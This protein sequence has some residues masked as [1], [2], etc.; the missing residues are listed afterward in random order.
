MS[1]DFSHSV[2]YKIICLNQDIKD[3]Y[4]GSTVKFERRKCDHKQACANPNGKLYNLK[5]YKCIRENGGWENWD[6]QIVE[7]V[8][9]KD[10]QELRARESYYKELLCATLNVATPSIFKMLDDGSKV[11]CNPITFE[12]TYYKEPGKSRGQWLRPGE[13]PGKRVIRGLGNYK[14]TYHEPKSGEGKG[15]YTRTPI[16]VNTL[17]DCGEQKIS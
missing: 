11:L 15:Y 8:K 2:I 17:S 4:V 1:S 5:V 14:W 7:H 9:C 6:M 3:C 13:E 10:S 16:D 12:L